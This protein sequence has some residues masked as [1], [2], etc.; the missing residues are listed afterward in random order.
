MM[1]PWLRSQVGIVRQ[2]ETAAIK[3]AE[4]SRGTFDR[5]LNAVYTSA[6]LEAS[7]HQCMLSSLHIAMCAASV[8]CPPAAGALPLFYPDVR[9]RGLGLW[10]L[11]G[12]SSNRPLTRACV[13]RQAQAGHVLEV[14]Q[15]GSERGVGEWTSAGLNA[16]LVA[17]VEAQVSALLIGPSVGMNCAP[18]KHAGTAAVHWS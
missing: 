4:G 6:T 1:P 18:L 11:Y 9:L 2:T 12:I 7:V 3:K 8:P 14:G 5:K 17:V 16:H 15:L 13:A 10:R